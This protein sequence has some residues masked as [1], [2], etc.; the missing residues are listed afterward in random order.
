MSKKRVDFTG[1]AAFVSVASHRSFRQAALELGVS[2]SA[3]SH[4]LRELEE[5]LGVRLLNRT[6][7]SVAPSDAGE[8]LLARLKPS[9]S[10]MEDALEEVN[11]FRETPVGTLRI[12][13]SQQAADLL[14]APL[15]ARF[16]RA[17]P[18]MHLEIVTDDALVDIV[19]NG[20]DAG[21]RFSESIEQD[22]IAVR[23]GRRLRWAIVASPDY[24][25]SHGKPLTP[26]DL[27]EHACIRYRFQSGAFFRWEFEKDGEALEVEVDGPLTLGDQKL[28]VRAALDGVG[29]AC[30]FDANVGAL[31]AEGRLVRVLA[32]HCPDFPGGFLYYPSRRQMPAGLRAFI[33]MARSEWGT[34][35]VGEA[36]RSAE[37]EGRSS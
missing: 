3:L 11:D 25:A 29:I 5:R 23:F 30:V 4:S 34:E 15:M 12:N 20:F 18:R 1:L 24:F 36:S 10:A 17:H 16:L 9:L 14:L 26:L 7:R 37:D 6:T 27:K 19:A 13:A 22:M 8:R 31:L 33:E 21:I 32:E 35:D 28:M 2:P